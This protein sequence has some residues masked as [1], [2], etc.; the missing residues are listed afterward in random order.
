MGPL[1][2]IPGFIPPVLC[3][4]NRNRQFTFLDNTG[5]HWPG[6]D[7][8]LYCFSNIILLL[9]AGTL[10]FI[11]FLAFHIPGGASDETQ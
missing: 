8:T 7:A 2:L 10:V 1:V 9:N 4:T 11:I 6:P 5:S 3:L